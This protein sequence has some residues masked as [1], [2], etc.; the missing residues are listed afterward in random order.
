[1]NLYCD[2]SIDWS[3][4]H[5]ILFIDI[6]FVEFKMCYTFENNILIHLIFFINGK[7]YF[8][9]SYY[10]ILCI[11]TVLQ[12]LLGNNNVRDN[13][14]TLVPEQGNKFRVSA[15]TLRPEPIS[16]NSLLKLVLPGSNLG[17]PHCSHRWATGI[18]TFPQL[19][20]YLYNNVDVDE[21]SVKAC[22]SPQPVWVLHPWPEISTVG[23][24]LYFSLGTQTYS[25]IS[26]S[27]ICFSVITTLSLHA[28]DSNC[29]V[30]G[31]NQSIYFIS[32]MIN[33]LCRG[34]KNRSCW[35][36][37]P[38]LRQNALVHTSFMAPE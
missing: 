28:R 29:A 25:Q 1:M 3:I 20:V 30:S 21:S 38:N 27:F 16:K 9:K 15:R 7:L 34:E 32:S 22:I 2:Q 11:E 4:F 12:E 19:I 10:S 18:V 33:I 37:C 17:R 14:T 35:Q 36:C 5:E 31:L 6:P 26:V 23:Y 24:N 13:H 8:F